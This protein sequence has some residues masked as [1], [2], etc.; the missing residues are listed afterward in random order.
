MPFA[1]G[2]EEARHFV[3]QAMNI[4][5]NVGDQLDPTQEQEN[6]ECQDGED[7]MHPD[8][9]QMNPDD[10]EFESNV[11]Q[12]KKTLK[13]IE[14]K[15]PD[16]LLREARDLDRYQKMVLHIAIEFAQD[17]IIAKKGKRQLPVAPLMM[18]HGGAGSGKSTVINVMSQYIH[19]ILRKD[20][21]DPDCPYVLLAAFTGSAASNISGQTLHTLFS[22]NF[23]AGFQSLNDQNRD[24]K[25]ALYKN[26]KVL[27]IDEISLV[28]PDLLYKID[29]RLREIT[30]NKSSIW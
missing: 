22:F 26:L 14:V 25:R 8:F 5:K 17:L 3:Q 4:E 10:F 24:K 20:G 16:E 11:K 23:G 30:Q 9:I 27:I 12:I 1:Q 2:V 28:E 21:D 6:L 15:S 7:L 19:K 29:L 13:N 18:V